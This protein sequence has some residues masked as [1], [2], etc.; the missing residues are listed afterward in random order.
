MRIL[1]IAPLPPPISGH[2]LAS[3]VFLDDLIKEHEVDVVN[4]SR[5]SFNKSSYIIRII[6][7]FSLLKE[8]WVK[9]KFADVIYLTISQ[10]IT[11]NLKDLFI[12]IICYRSLHKMLIHLHGGAGMRNIL[13]KKKSFLGTINSFFI[14]RLGGIIV[15]GPSQVDIFSNIVPSDKIHVVY[16]FAED[17]LFINSEQIQKKFQ[18]TQ[19]LRLLFLSNLLPGKGYNELLEAYFA[20][21]EDLRKRIVIDFAGD[22]ESDIDRV[23]FLNKIYGHEQLHYHGIVTGSTKKDIFNMAHVFCLPTYYSYEGQPISILEAYASGCAV[24][25]TN[26]S[27]IRDIFEDK[28]NGFEIHKKSSGSIKNVIEQ[29]LNAPEQLLSL[30]MTNS[31]IADEKHRTSLYNAS[32]IKIIEN[33]AHDTRK[34]T[35]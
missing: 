24:M 8:V 31:Q 26:H 17:Y 7:I 10:S 20:L 25:T 32:L 28:I 29:I 12:Y 1:F 30:A 3:K 33:I 16:N 14:R 22:F 5:C 23:D 6:Q 18:A 35:Q 4:F 13:L 21:H 9:K 27:G 19:T 15:L 34:S 11:G 2:S